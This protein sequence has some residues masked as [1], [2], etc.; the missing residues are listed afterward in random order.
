MEHQMLKIKQT[1]DFTVWFSNL[2][3]KEQAQVMARLE[4]IIDHGHFGD[5][6]SLGDSL[7]ELRWKNG[8]RV[9]FVLTNELIIL[10]V[11]VHKNE[12][13]KNIKKARI[14]IFKYT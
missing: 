3:K 1:K 6:K 5:S 12:Q 2:T 13:D 8:W 7:C 14:N 11:C 4:R 9:Y 10:I